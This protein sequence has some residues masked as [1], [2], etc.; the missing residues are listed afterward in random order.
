MSNT[1]K[2]V[3]KKEKTIKVKCSH[4][5]HEMEMTEKE[6]DEYWNWKCTECFNIFNIKK[7]TPF[8]WKCSRPD[9]PRRNPH[10]MR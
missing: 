10:N 1:K 8:H 3:T 5:N 2:K 9:T 7:C 6:Y 4:C